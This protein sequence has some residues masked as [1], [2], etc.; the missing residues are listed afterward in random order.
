MAELSLYGQGWV[1]R[2]LI[3]DPP[4]DWYHVYATTIGVTQQ[5]AIE[6]AEFTLQLL[7][8]HREAVIRVK[9]EASSH[10]DFDTK[11]TRHRG[12]VRFSMKLDPGSWH[13]SESTDCVSLSGF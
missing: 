7:A 13:Q 12:F 1:S 5:A 2:I 8:A 11:E 6:A 10:T 9:P 4:Q 3:S